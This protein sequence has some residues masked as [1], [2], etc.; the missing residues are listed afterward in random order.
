VADIVAAIA[1]ASAEQATGI[2][3]VNK[4]LSQ[5]DG[6]T[7]QNSAPVEENAATA[8][9]MEQKARHMDE[10]ISFFNLGRAKAPAAAPARAA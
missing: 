8:K 4:A 5:M 9:T 1:S 2:D 7:Q 6:V 10:R 3:Q